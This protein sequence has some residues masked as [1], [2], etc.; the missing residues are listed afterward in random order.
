MGILFVL[1]TILATFALHSAS[2]PLTASTFLAGA[3]AIAVYA[4]LQA[5]LKIDLIDVDGPRG[6]VTEIGL[7]A[8]TVHEVLNAGAEAAD[9]AG[10]P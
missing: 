3:L 8:S 2:I 5:I 9:A 7:R 10:G 4:G 6:R 1:T